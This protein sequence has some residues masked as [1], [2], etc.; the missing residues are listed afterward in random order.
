MWKIPL[1]KTFFD[2]REKEALIKQI[3]SDWVSMGET[4]V[5]FEEKIKEKLKIP[6]CLCVSNCTV[7][8]HLACLVAGFGPG[9]EVI[10]PSLS[11]IATANA[12]LYTGATPVFADIESIVLPVISLKEI[13]Q[14]FT[15]KTKGIIVVHYGGYQ[16][17]IFEIKKFAEKHSLKLIEDCAH[18]I[19]ST[20][21]NQHL[22]TIGDIGCFS[23]FGNKNITT[24]EGG[25]IITHNKDIY[26]KLKTLRSHGMKSLSWDKFKGRHLNKDIEILGYNY[27][28]DDIR[29]S[30]GLVQLGKLEHI[31]SRRRALINQYINNLKD[32]SD[33]TIPFKDY[34]YLHSAHLFSI[35][36]AD[37]KQKEKVVQALKDNLIQTSHHYPPIHKYKLYEK[38]SYELPK[39]EMYS[40][41]QVTLPLYPELKNVEVS[42][43]CDV[44][45][46][47][48][49]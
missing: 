1:S 42:Y 21:E 39:T 43:I 6:H 46:E 20:V 3:D 28:F 37:E 49:D 16:H 36:C 11:F 14:K 30:I 5:I 15:N 27:R 12:V 34:P 40:K 31:N 41:L 44:M 9:D 48:L 23:F 22:G 19:G 38:Y 45:K 10:V 25:A 8:L 33:F 18:S 24:G 13:K 35:I 32:V 26:E 47:A 7:A 4:T 29:A 2:K 17:N